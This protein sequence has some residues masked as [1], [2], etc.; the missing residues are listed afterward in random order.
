MILQ[1]YQY[2]QESDG[3][4]ANGILEAGNTWPYGSTNPN[5]LTLSIETEDNGSP[6]V[7][8]VTDKQYASVLALVQGM[9]TR[10]PSLVNLATHTVI[11]PQSRPN[12]PGARWVASGRMSQLATDTGLTLLS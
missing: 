4:W 7:V 9:R 11:S 2:V 5:Y 3:A 10:W 6:D 1:L 12:C 8:T